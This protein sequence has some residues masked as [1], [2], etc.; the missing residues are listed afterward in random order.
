[1]KFLRETTPF[2]QIIFT[3]IIILMG[4]IILSI[5]GFFG[6]WIWKGIPFEAL[7]GM[8]TNFADPGNVGLLK[9]FQIL[10][11]IG[12]FILPPILLAYALDNKPYRF[13]SLDKWPTD[14]KSV[15]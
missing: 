10:Q 6:I 9:F 15:V 4:G 8:L 7:S 11:T 13:L 5:L 3:L 14:R 2:T 1:M 12:M